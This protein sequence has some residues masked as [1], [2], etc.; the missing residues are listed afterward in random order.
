MCARSARASAPHEMKLTGKD[1]DYGFFASLRM[2]KNDTFP[3][4]GTVIG[5]PQRTTATG[6]PLKGIA[7]CRM[8]AISPPV[9]VLFF[10]ISLNSL[11]FFPNP[12]IQSFCGTT[13]YF[14][15]HKSECFCF[16]AKTQAPFLMLVVCMESCVAAMGARVFRAWSLAAMRFLFPE[17]RMDIIIERSPGK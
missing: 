9:G 3:P 14:T 16:T 5:R 10:L 17:S 7:S 2:T 6:G 8:A 11:A 4:V 12:V 13:P 1:G 15:N